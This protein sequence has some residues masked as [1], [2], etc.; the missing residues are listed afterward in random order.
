M[1]PGGGPRQWSFCLVSP[2]ARRCRRF[3]CHGKQS[4]HLTSPSHQRPRPGPFSS[5]PS[6]AVAQVGDRV[7]LALS[8][9]PGTGGCCCSARLQIITSLPDL[10]LGAR[11][12]AVT[13]GQRA[14]LANQGQEKTRCRLSI[15]RQSSRECFQKLPGKPVPF[16]HCPP[17]SPPGRSQFS[18]MEGPACSSR[19]MGL[20]CTR[21]Y[22]PPEMALIMA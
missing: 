20:S 10:C 4:H 6:L 11:E 8:S 22:E 13:H 18:Q 19:L 5:S 17:S 12:Q 14:G 2:V 7:A 9:P 15:N 16:S 1:A 21:R 3:S